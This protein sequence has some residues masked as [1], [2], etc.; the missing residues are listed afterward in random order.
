MEKR[1]W[2]G[3]QVYPPS[4]LALFGVDFVAKAAWLVTP[5][6]G[7]AD[8]VTVQFDHGVRLCTASHG[9]NEGNFFAEMRV[10]N[11]PIPPTPVELDLDLLGLAA[12]EEG[13]AYNGA[14]T[15]FIPEKFVVPPVD[16]APF[17]I[18]SEANNLLITGSGFAAPMH[19]D[20]ANGP[21]KLTIYFKIADSDTDYALHLKHWK[22]TA[23]G[24]ILTLVAN[25]NSESPIVK[26]VDA[27]EAE[28]GERNLLSIVLRN[29]DYSS[30][31]FHDYL[32]LGLN[33]LDITIEPDD[34]QTGSQATAGYALRALAIG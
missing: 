26:H 1:L 34:G 4:E 12:I 18:A 7:V 2:D 29:R 19:T 22:T 15:G 14:V 8:L 31:D 25:G 3:E 6:A 11:P 33:R 32:Q 13:G 28:G 16:G 21:A 5:K 10:I 30:E 17:K 24:S 9:V 27:L 20:F 23:T